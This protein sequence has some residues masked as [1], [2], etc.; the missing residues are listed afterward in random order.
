VDGK[1]AKEFAAAAAAK[2]SEIRADGL[3]IYN[4]LP[5]AGFVLTKKKYNPNPNPNIRIG[6]TFSSPTPKP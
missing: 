3:S 1:T 5:E 2:G 6:Y 4:G